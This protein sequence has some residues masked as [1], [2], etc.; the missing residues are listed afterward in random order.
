MLRALSLLLLIALTA[1]GKSEDLPLGLVTRGQE[2]RLD[3]VFKNT[4]TQP[5]AIGQANTSCDCFKILQ[6]PGWVE[7][8]ASVRIPVSYRAESVGRIA[9]EVALLAE[10]NSIAVAEYTIRGVSIEPEWGISPASLRAKSAEPVVLV[11]IRSADKFARVHLP[12]SLNVLPFALR[13]RTDLRDR[14]VVLIDEGTSPVE[15]FERVAAMREQGFRQVF[16]LSGGVAEWLRQGGPVEGSAPTALAASQITP[17]EWSISRRDFVWRV[18]S[19]SPVEI[20]DALATGLVVERWDRLASALVPLTKRPQSLAENR[21]VLVPDEATAAR[22]E[23]QLA[24]AQVNTHVFY[25]IGGEAA[26]QAYR[27][28]Q[29]SVTVN[30]PQRMQARPAHGQPMPGRSGGCGSCGRK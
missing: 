21:L 16:G 2:I 17:A 20:D 6:M 4:A 29:A 25:L 1:F 13:T 18:I 12:R 26:L 3:L 28:Q 23:A 27:V 11:D 24:K 5:V 30:S 7:P 10:G 15:L 9:V 14:R 22:L 8:G 19:Q